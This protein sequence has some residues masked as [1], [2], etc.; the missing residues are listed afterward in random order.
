MAEEKTLHIK[1]IA[2]NRKARHN[3]T[4]EET[5]EA[6]VCLRGTEVKALRD[7]K[8]TLNDAHAIFRGHELFL[9]NAYIGHYSHGNVNNHETIRSRKLLLHH[10][11]LQKLWSK[12]EIRGYSLVPLKV[13]FK[14]GWAKVEIAIAKGKK[15]FDKRQTERER[16]SKREMAKITKKIHHR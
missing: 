9:V 4:I 16:E 2:E 11:E 6:G 3:Y 5:V 1:I 15:D 12:K 14:N 13:Y 7:S 8:L 10:S